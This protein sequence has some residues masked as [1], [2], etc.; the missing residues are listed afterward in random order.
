MFA[1]HFHELTELSVEMK[2]VKNLK[3]AA[4]MEGGELTL[5]YHVLPGT[6]D[7]SLGVPVAET[8]GF[9]AHVVEVHI[10]IM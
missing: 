3:V 4:S 5:L 1:T 10:R 8:L 6:A 9:P 7:Q 2:T